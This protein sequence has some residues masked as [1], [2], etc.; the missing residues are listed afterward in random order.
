M[1]YTEYL[2]VIP[3][4]NKPSSSTL[5]IFNES[6]FEE[7]RTLYLQSNGF[8][9]HE[10]PHTLE[11][12]AIDHFRPPPKHTFQRTLTFT[13]PRKR[14]SEHLW[15]HSR[16]PIKQPLLKKLMNKDEFIQESSFAFND[17]LFIFEF[18]HFFILKNLSFAILFS[19]NFS[20]PI[21]K[22]MGDL[23]SRR[24]R[25]TN[26]LTDQ[27]FEGPLKYVSFRAVLIKL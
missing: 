26:E 22:Y 4:T 15:K 16:D 24:I 13:S 12:Y 2:Y 17:I 23:P 6:N 11:E 21:L 25:N 27:I 18:N 5:A 9:S 19:L 7:H 14:N 10:K 3:T 8:N 1:L 20:A